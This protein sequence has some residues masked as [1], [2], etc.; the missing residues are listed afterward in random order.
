MNIIFFSTKKHEEALF[1]QANLEYHHKITFLNCTL[2]KSTATLA[3]GYDVVCCFV[4]DHL[5]KTVL[6][7]LHL[8]GIKLIA[9]RSSG[10]NHVNMKAAHQIGIP[11]CHV[12]N[13]SP[14]AIAEHAVALILTLNRKT[15]RAYNRVKEFNFSLEGLEGFDLHGKTVG[16]IGTGK[17]GYRF[18][19]I[20]KGFGCKLLGYDINQNPLCLELGVDYVP[21]DEIYNRSHI[22]SLHCPLNSHTYRLINTDAIQKMRDKV[23]LINTGRGGLIDTKA[24][25]EG[26]KNE[27]IGYLGLDV[28]EEEENLFF[29]DLSTK[30]IKDEDFIR[31]H[32]FPNV[33]ITSHQGF[34]T[35]EALIGIAKT[36]LENITA[37]E[38]KRLINEVKSNQN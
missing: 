28:Y 18:A 23:M 9:L 8:E 14:Y 31:L 27:K 17:I 22:I 21:I 11:V 32:S 20:L 19:S 37:F 26:L 5:N 2:N 33:I 30:V 38:Q 6:E 36:T 34:F 1:T 24:I 10:Y 15:H 7:M 29:K 12:P 25:I 3:K 16:I 35:R 4:E 13:Y